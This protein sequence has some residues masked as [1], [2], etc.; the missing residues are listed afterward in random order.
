MYMYAVPISLPCTVLSTLFVPPTTVT[1]KYAK[2][3][4]TL[5]WLGASVGQLLWFH[6]SD[7]VGAM[8]WLLLLLLQSRD[9]DG[10][11]YGPLVS[12]VTLMTSV[13]ATAKGILLQSST[14]ESTKC[15]LQ[16][17]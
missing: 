5:V 14:L 16:P 2:E 4:R 3:V 7:Q 17:V 10:L 9:S 12:I 8:V 15:L 1:Q 11:K 6:G 13:I